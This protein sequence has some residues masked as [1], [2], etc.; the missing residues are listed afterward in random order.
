M[1][2]K[3]IQV[4]FELA[5]N[6]ETQA[7]DLYAKFA[8]LFSHEPKVSAFW[9][10]LSKDESRHRKVLKGFLKEIPGEKLLAE[11]GNEEQRSVIRVE[12]LINEATTSKIQTLDDAYELAH[13]L[14]TSEI[15]KVFKMLVNHYMPDKE[16]HKFILSDVKEHIEMLVKFGKEYTQSQRRRINVRSI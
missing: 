2:E 9:K 10:Q 6:W 4:L 3:T 16:G 5:I 12:G 14:E 13:Q 1:A 7:Y 8:K 15:N 11:M